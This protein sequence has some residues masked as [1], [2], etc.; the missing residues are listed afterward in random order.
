MS[1]AK[2]AFVLLLAAGCADPSGVG[3][4]TVGSTASSSGSTG[5]AGAMGG[6][7]GAGAMG[8]AAMG[9]MGA[10]ASG[11][12]AGGMD[13][14]PDQGQG[15]AN[16]TM[17]TATQ[18]AGGTDCDELSTQG[19]IDGPNDVDWYMYVQSDDEMFC[20]VNPARDWAV[21]GGATIRVCKY[22]EC[23]ANN[24]SPGT[25]NCNGGSTPDT[26]GGLDGCCHTEPFDVG[27]G[28]TGC[29]GLT[30]LLNVYT[31]ID[32]PD[33]PADACTDYNL[34]YTF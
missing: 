3:G 2:L 32:Q 5:G 13:V 12:G 26:Q 20:N 11:T 33:A 9:G 14:C 24:M 19:T 17:A 1:P 6:A 18:L 23:Q 7:G 28:F 31:R 34:N 21:S 30:D 10:G 29:S 15:E 25:V 27:I 8:G 4:T 22:V 16:D